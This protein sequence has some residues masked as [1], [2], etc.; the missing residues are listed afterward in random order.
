MLKKVLLYFLLLTGPGPAA[1]PAD[2]VQILLH[3]KQ[4]DTLSLLR[5][6]KLS[7]KNTPNN[8]QEAL[9]NLQKALK[10]AQQL[11]YPPGVA[12]TYVAIG[13][14]FRSM[15]QYDS[16]RHYYRTAIDMLKTLG[17]SKDLITVYNNIGVIEKETGNF[18]TA[19]NY[20]IE[21]LN[22]STALRD[23]RGTGRAYS[24]IGIVYRNM[25]NL[26]KALEYQLKALHYDSLAKEKNSMGK[27]LANLGNIYLDKKDARKAVVYFERSLQ[28]FRETDDKPSLAIICNNTAETYAE[29]GDF[30]K[31]A[32]YARAGL[33]YAEEV[34][35]PM[36]RGHAMLM[37]GEL[38]ERQGFY[39]V[40][41]KNFREAL[42]IFKKVGNNAKLK[43]TYY[44]LAQ[45][46]RKARQFEKAIESYELY[47]NFKDSIFN[48]DFARQISEMEQKYQ[49]SQQQKQIEILK[50]NESIKDL[51]LRQKN[52]TIYAAIALG[53]AL[54]L[55]LG[56]V[57]RSLQRNRRMNDMLEGRNEEI[58]RQKFIIEEKNKDIIDSLNYARRLQGNILPPDPFINNLFKESF[59]FYKPK[60]IVSG[61][62]YWIETVG[63]EV[64][65][66]AV[67][68]TGH[69]VPGAI[70]SIVGYNLLNKILYEE[71][72]TSCARILDSLVLNLARYL[73][74]D[75][76]TESI[77]N[78]GMDVAL[79]RVN[80]K[81]GHTRF[82]GAFSPAVVVTDGVL[83][84][85]K[86]DKFS[87]GRHT[88]EGRYRFSESE[89]VI[90]SGSMLYL[91]SDG[92]ADQFG[93]QK[94]KKFMRRN[95]YT[96]LQELAPLPAALQ[97]QRLGE[98][99]YDWKQNITQVDDICVLG[100]RI[101]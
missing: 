68:C 87:V 23:N 99:F 27:T 2:S 75:G 53:V 84:E 44:N 48:H 82:A 67:D 34:K 37:L 39:A 83:T 31:A 64:Y 4:H 29:L 17:R 47:N 77:S 93:G 8:P 11:K 60:D 13:F 90:G 20:Y 51:Q 96:L 88:Y 57:Y 26:D 28:I 73:R 46:Y 80:R 65:I 70:M 19:I 38:S 97:K 101:G 6:V 56:F 36:L 32:E 15:S 12:K 100:F 91:F 24:N 1:Q 63:D 85:Y 33:S 69:G 78:D 94:G 50:Q 92:Y 14:A 98:V 7:Q 30:R 76:R 54:L 52:I 71:K 41:E 49:S 40:A 5:L 3:Q 72:Q 81:T 62:F 9:V 18:P 35:D 66:A 89:F 16:A 74:Q 45:M 42:G 58:S 22:L 25:K 43:D 86:P 10:V 55:F 59:V 61:D 21:S 79:C 95:F